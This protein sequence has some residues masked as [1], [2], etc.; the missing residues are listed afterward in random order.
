MEE[1]DLD[2][3]VGEY[4]TYIITHDLLFEENAT[5]NIFKTYS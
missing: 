5:T 2:I 3:F 4:G 1:N